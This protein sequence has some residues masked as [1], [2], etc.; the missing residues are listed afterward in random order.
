MNIKSAHS[1]CPLQH[2]Q[3][4]HPKEYWR[5]TD[6]IVLTALGSIQESELM[7]TAAPSGPPPPARS[8]LKTASPHL[9]VSTNDIEDGGFDARHPQQKDK[10][11]NDPVA[12]QQQW[13]L[14]CPLMG[15][16]QHL[17]AAAA[18]VGHWAGESGESRREAWC[19]WFHGDEHPDMAWSEQMPEGRVEIL[20]SRPG[21][22]KPQAMPNPDASHPSREA[23][24]NG[25][26]DSH[27][28]R[29]LKEHPAI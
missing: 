9:T 8:R 5:P 1:G 27:D 21:T 10:D 17:Q 20:G 16:R 18:G 15:V 26:P 3:G 7:P 19:N 14:L 4:H 23:C 28:Q 29:G 12:R 13:L 24:M 11:G 2:R 6:G 25:L 22:Q